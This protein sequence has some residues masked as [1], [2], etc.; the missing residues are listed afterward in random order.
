MTGTVVLQETIPFTDPK[1]GRHVLWHEESRQYP[2][3]RVSMT[4]R[5]S[6]VHKWYGPLYDQTYGS[7]TINATSSALNTAPNHKPYTRR[8]PET[9]II[10]MYRRVTQ[11]DPF[12]GTF[13]PDDTGSN[14]LSA[15]KVQVEFQHSNRYEWG[16]GLEHCLDALV[17]RPGCFG[18]NWYR[19]MFR[20]DAN[21]FIEPTGPIDGGHEWVSVG[22]DFEEE[23]VWCV[24]SWGKWGI[25]YAPHRHK[26]GYFKV[27]FSVL[28]RL[29]R[30]NGDFV[31]PIREW[32]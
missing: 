5:V 8:I 31:Q 7:C 6:T 26:T 13:E 15:C 11:I 16:F 25:G 20:P 18:T 1:L 4:E 10:P 12:H 21:G 19:G 27:R 23:F 30:E 28:D 24:Q 22:V 9:K 14:G 32:S 29:L 2:A 3:R 17:L